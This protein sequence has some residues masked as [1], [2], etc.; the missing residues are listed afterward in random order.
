MKIESLSTFLEGLNVCFYRKDENDIINLLN[1]SEDL[2]N[3]LKDILKTCN[4]FNLCYD[5][6]PFL[7]IDDEKNCLILEGVLSENVDEGYLTKHLSI[8]ESFDKVTLKS[9]CN[10]KL[11]F[12]GSYKNL[13]EVNLKHEIIYLIG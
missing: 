1:T 7:K 4:T 6:P 5:F 2:A 9:S 10:G 12:K 13:L 3:V 8:D 11:N